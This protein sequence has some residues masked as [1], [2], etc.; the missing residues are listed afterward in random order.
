MGNYSCSA[1]NEIG[2]DEQQVTLN[3]KPTCKSECPFEGFAVIPSYRDCTLYYIC[4][5]GIQYARE[6]PSGEIFDSATLAC[7][8]PKT[9]VCASKAPCKS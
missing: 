9:S 8:D 4:V 5:K 6:C 1:V 7:G 3:L 2:K